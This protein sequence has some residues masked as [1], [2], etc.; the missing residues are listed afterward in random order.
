MERLHELI[1]R[2]PPGVEFLIV[3]TW[4][5]GLHIFSSILSI[6]QPEA[7]R[8]DDKSLFSLMFVELLQFGFLAWFLRIRGWTLEKFG[9]R[10]TWGGTA[11]GVGLAVVTYAVLLGILIAAEFA[12]PS[13]VKAARAWYP[14]VAPELS[15]QLVFVASV[16]NGIY[17]ELFV[18]GYIV[19]ALKERRGM[20][21][22]INVSTVVR[23]LY[24]LYQGPIGVLVVI[25][26][27]LAWGYLYARR[28]VLWPLILAH[29]LIDIAGLIAST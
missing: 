10:V 5:F 21:T 16:I 29:V 13:Q 7:Q 6:G 11:A 20:W 3:L 12:L 25:P 17:E 19:T 24:H 1:R 8:F 2:L 23:V 26:L 9:L 4:A 28:G 22:A 15:M 27:G 18:A 14:T